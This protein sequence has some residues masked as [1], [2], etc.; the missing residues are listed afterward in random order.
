MSKSSKTVFKLLLIFGGVGIL[1][2]GFFIAI[3]AY[4]SREDISN[5]EPYVS[6]LNIPQEV[7]VVST[8]RWNK[9][10]LRFKNYSLVVNEDS[11]YDMEDVKSVKQYQP[12]D[13]ITFYSAKSYYSIHVDKTYYLLARDTLAS[14]KVIEFEYY[15]TPRTLPFN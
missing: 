9:N 6:F 15:Y 7:K 2:I 14:G 5:Q 8:I 1:I 11:H 3:L 10:N 13:F 4:E 12:G